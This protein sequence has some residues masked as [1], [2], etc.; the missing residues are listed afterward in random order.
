MDTLAFVYCFPLL[1]RIRDLH[2]LVI[3]HA[4]RT[5][6]SAIDEVMQKNQEEIKKEVTEIKEKLNEIAKILISAKP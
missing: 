4:R 2:S 5:F 1:G 3:A 6:F